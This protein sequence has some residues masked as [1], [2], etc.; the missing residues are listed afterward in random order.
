M[1]S[2]KI[3]F[4]ERLG[5]GFGDLASNL[6]WTATGM[7]LTF[8]YTDIVGISAAAVGTLL[9]IARVFDA[10]VDLGI[11][12]LVDKTKSKYGKARPWLKWFAIPYGIAGILLF[13][14]PNFGPTGALIY[15]YITYL[16]VNVIYSAINV[17]YSAL[18]SLITQDQYQRSVLNI[19]RMFCALVGMLV[20]TT[21]T[22]P[23]V[24]AFGGGK[25]G[26][27][28]TFIM[29]GVVSSVLFLITFRTTKERV[30]PSVVQKDIPIKRGFKALFRNKYW[31]IVVVL[32]LIGGI[33]G[34]I[35]NAVGIYYYQYIMNDR[36]LV[37]LLGL[38]G[39][40]PIII[41]LLFV[42]PIIKKYGKRNSMLVGLVIILIGCF[43]L[44]INPTSL[45]VIITSILIKSI[46]SVPIA[47]AGFAL[48]ADTIEYG[49]WKTGIRT[50]GL[51][52]SAGSFGTKAGNGIG[53]ATVG[54]LLAMGGY[55]GGQEVISATASNTI[56]FM[57]I[58]IPIIF[59]VIQ[60]LILIPYKLDKEYPEVI[61]DLTKAKESIS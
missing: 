46:G 30:T 31:I 21:M 15:A 18:N 13:T 28:S 9:L 56:E 57:Y 19:F 58:Y 61:A 43:I 17:P 5:Y 40:V 44:L 16:L 54:W 47:A 59:T 51:V 26:W 29:F 2:Q 10:F 14:A 52:Y 36:N 60:L 39:L 22:L 3:K 37:G 33:S 45:S 41:G 55:V 38:I 23:I 35:S 11:G 12:G 20:I 25:A 27:S 49:E 24:D 50:E 6:I 8:F 34:A 48:L 53:A 1:H 42:A 4:S 32:M 7:F